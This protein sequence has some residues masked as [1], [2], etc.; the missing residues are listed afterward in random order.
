M[1][2]ENEMEEFMIYGNSFQNEMPSQDRPVEVHSVGEKMRGKCGATTLMRTARS[3]HRALQLLIHWQEPHQVDALV[4][5]G[6]LQMQFLAGYP[7]AQEGER[8]CERIACD[9]CH[10]LIF[11]K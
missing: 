10:E 6:S 11:P 4:C 3:W 2:E 9:V 8:R 1:S 7:Y 5:K